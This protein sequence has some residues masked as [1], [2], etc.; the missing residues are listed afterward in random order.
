M[1]TLAFALVLGLVCV[2][3]GCDKDASKPA[4]AAAPSGS[5]S[6]AAPATSKAGGGW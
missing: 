4:N 5:P 2:L 6:S 1:K 3:A